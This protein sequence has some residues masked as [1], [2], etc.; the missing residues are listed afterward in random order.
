METLLLSD[1]HNEEMREMYDSLTEVIQLTVDLLRDA[2]ASEAAAAAVAAPGQPAAAGGQPQQRMKCGC[3]QTGQTGTQQ[4][5]H[6][7]VALYVT[8]HAM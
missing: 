4:A 1:P 3:A 5:A 8:S 2:G 7:A 6:R